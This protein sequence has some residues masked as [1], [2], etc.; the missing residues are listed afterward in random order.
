MY[1]C[2]DIVTNARFWACTKTVPIVFDLYKCHS[3]IMIWLFDLTALSRTLY[4]TSKT[5]RFG[6]V[7][8]ALDHAALKLWLQEMVDF[9]VHNRHYTM[10]WLQLTVFDLNYNRH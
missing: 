3:T 1:K 4:E 2:W 9:N 10:I 5:C 7:H 6:F 8:T